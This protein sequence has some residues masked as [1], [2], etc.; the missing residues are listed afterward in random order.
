M[1]QVRTNGY[2]LYNGGDNVDILAGRGTTT[3][4]AR[5]NTVGGEYFTL[6]GHK[7]F[8]HNSGA[9]YLGGFTIRDLTADEV[10]T[11]VNP[12]GNMGYVTGGNYSVAN[13]LFAEKINESSCYIYQYCPAN[14]MAMYRL[15]DRKSSIESIASPATDNCLKVYPNPATTAIN[16]TNGSKLGSLTVFSMTGTQMVPTIDY[17]DQNNATINISAMPAGIYFVHDAN[18][19]TTAKFIKK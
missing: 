11:S 13:W 15:V 12:I 6:S 9:N 3:A 8:I 19:G 10:I 16:V 7:L 4:P 2:Y 5:N 17:I 18:T 1:Y 14:G